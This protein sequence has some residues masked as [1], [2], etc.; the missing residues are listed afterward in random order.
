MAEAG[1]G[2]I[3]M[4]LPSVTSDLTSDPDVEV[5]PRSSEPSSV[6]ATS[7]RPVAVSFDPV[8]R[9]VYWS[10]VHDRAIYR[11]SVDGGGQREV[12][13]NASHGVGFVEGMCNFHR[14]FYIMLVKEGASVVQ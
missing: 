14:K 3:I 9:H 13:L 8:G 7:P 5:P 12:L 1:A 10:D 6:F 11:M 4:T 2:Q